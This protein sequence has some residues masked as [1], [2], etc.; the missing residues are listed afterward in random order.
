MV[1]LGALETLG[2]RLQGPY[3]FEMII[4]ESDVKISDAIMELQT[5]GAQATEKVFNV[6]ACGRPRIASS[7]K[8]GKRAVHN[9]DIG[10][11][12]QVPE[13]AKMT[14]KLSTSSAKDLV[15]ANFRRSD[16]DKLVKEIKKVMGNSVG[17]WK[18]LPFTLCDQP[19]PEF[20]EKNF[21]WKAPL[22]NDQCWNGR[23][24]GPYRSDIVQDGLENFVKNPE[25]E[26]HNS[27][28]AEPLILKEQSGKL[29]KITNE[30]KS[31]HN[32]QEVDWWD[33][34][35]LNFR[36]K[37][38]FFQQLIFLFLK[39]PELAED[40][41]QFNEGSGSGDYES[42]GFSDDEDYEDYYDH[43]DHEGS[44][45][46]DDEYDEDTADPV[47]WVPWSPPVTEEPATEKPSTSTP[48][49]TTR[50]PVTPSSTVTPPSK[51]KDSGTSMMSANM[52]IIVSCCVMFCVW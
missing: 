50:T 52:A 16:F 31:A 33:Q 22:I 49:F 8:L 30:L 37:N 7:R 46:G 41:D 44:G 45:S 36:A 35:S 5:K 27:R 15:R 47:P 12:D 38:P 11:E 42:P 20:Q 6:N 17:F 51:P 3:D 28:I 40:N 13:E 2:E 14:S 32:G 39:E 10:F 23:D 48:E 43:E 34:V 21:G 29:T 24:N 19:N 26:S 25:M 9:E 4:M 1:T 18:E